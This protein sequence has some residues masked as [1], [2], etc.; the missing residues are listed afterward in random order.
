VPVLSS[1]GANVQRPPAFATG[2]SRFPCYSEADRAARLRSA[3]EPTH[4]NSS[5]FLPTPV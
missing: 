2:K 3:A 4:N 5:I 1:I